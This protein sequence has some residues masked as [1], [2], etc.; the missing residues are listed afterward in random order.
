MSCRA[1]LIELQ[2][3]LRDTSCFYIPSTTEVVHVETN[4]HM[5]IPMQAKSSGGRLL[6]TNAGSAGF[7]TN[8]QGLSWNQ[9]F[10]RNVS[11]SKNISLHF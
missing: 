1:K 4:Q 6:A 8:V 5:T 7:R 2:V 3:S 10:L 11:H 9:Y